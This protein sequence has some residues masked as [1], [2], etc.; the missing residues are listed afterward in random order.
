[1]Q[2][3]KQTA[4]RYFG[5]YARGKSVNKDAAFDSNL[6][7]QSRITKIVTVFHSGS[8]SIHHNHLAS[9]CSPGTRF[10]ASAKFH[11]PR[12]CRAW[13]QY[14]STHDKYHC[15]LLITTKNRA[16]NNYK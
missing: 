4:I 1:M 16:L 8:I 5:K 2:H 10:S 9:I 12:F 3:Y 13:L 6:T 14:L 15:Q 11:Q 7:I